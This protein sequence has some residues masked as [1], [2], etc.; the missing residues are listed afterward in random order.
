M[1]YNY[2]VASLYAICHFQPDHLH[3][4]VP[5]WDN[6]AKGHG[7]TPSNRIIHY[8]NAVDGSTIFPKPAVSKL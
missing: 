2:V 3:S 4:E 5:C 1:L 6:N 7:E 8:R